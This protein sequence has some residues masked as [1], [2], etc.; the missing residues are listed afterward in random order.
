MR[1]CVLLLLKFFVYLELRDLK[2]FTKEFSV[3][4]NSWDFKHLTFPLSCFDL[5]D[6][7]RHKSVVLTLKNVFNN[8]SLQIN[9]F[10]FFKFEKV[11]KISEF[12]TL[13]I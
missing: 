3:I 6:I 11:M 2:V 4:I 13:L 5:S 9:M 7:L 12:K 10:D 1:E 8:S